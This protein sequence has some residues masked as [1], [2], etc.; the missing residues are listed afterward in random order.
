MDAAEKDMSEW[1]ELDIIDII[2]KRP[3]AFDSFACR[4]AAATEKLDEAYRL[5]LEAIAAEA[6]R[7]ALAAEKI[8]FQ[9][10]QDE[11]RIIARREAIEGLIPRTH[12]EPFNEQAAPH[13]FAIVKAFDLSKAGSLLIIGKAGSGKARA[14]HHHLF[15]SCMGGIIPPFLTLAASDVKTHLSP[16]SLGPAPSY[17]P[18]SGELETERVVF[19]RDIHLASLSPG[20]GRGL[21]T[22]LGRRSDDGLCTIISTALGGDALILA[23]D[24]AG[25]NRDLANEL[26]DTLAAWQCADF[27]E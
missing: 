25:F 13:D 2:L 9:A 14:A 26:F 5:A 15:Q 3:K 16:K 17:A 19:I 7:A 22:I 18:S 6:A 20:Y 11:A 12:R 23:W 21:L 4:L 1:H 24:K 27:D 8:A 10:K